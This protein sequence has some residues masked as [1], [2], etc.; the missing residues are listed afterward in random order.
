MPH[1]VRLALPWVF[2]LVGLWVSVLLIN[3]TAPTACDELPDA[4]GAGKHTEASGDGL[5][6][7]KCA[8]TDPSTGST[9]EVTKINWSGIIASVAGC[10]GAWFLGASLGGIIDRRRGVTIA[11]VLLLVSAVALLAFFL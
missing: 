8:V 6:F 2:L 3:G 1:L 9:A 5:G 7:A 4:F 11:L 10:I